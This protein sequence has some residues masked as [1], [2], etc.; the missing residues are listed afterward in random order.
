[1]ILVDTSVWADHFR[2]ADSDLRI[3]LTTGRVAMHAFVMGELAVGNLRPWRATLDALRAL[4]QA[5]VASERELLALV[6]RERLAGSGIGFVDAHLL[7]ATQATPDLR[8]W[9]RDR[10]LDAKAGALGLS[11]APA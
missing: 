2:S 10:R 8:L 3:L 7:A 6:D 1:M 9:T 5:P 11:W 4:P